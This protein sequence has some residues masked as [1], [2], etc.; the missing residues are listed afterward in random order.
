MQFWYVYIDV[1]I[2]RSHH[3]NHHYIK[4][5]LYGLLMNCSESWIQQNRRRYPNMI[6]RRR[7]H[8][9]RIDNL[10]ENISVI[11]WLVQM[12]ILDLCDALKIWLLI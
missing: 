4:L 8:K 7:A 3:S 6:H 10:M 9:Q 1:A 12:V 2:D 11:I 5:Y